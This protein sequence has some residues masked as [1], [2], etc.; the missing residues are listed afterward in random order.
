MGVFANAL[1]IAIGQNSPATRAIPREQGS[2]AAFLL[3]RFHR[4][5]Q[6]EPRLSLVERINLA[7]RQTVALI[8][9]DGQKFLVASSP[10][11][12][13]TFYALKT[14]GRSTVNR[15]RKTASEGK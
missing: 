6:K 9:A 5:A 4:R 8:E 2:L 7:P 10:D 14:A 3:D 11:G 1:G 13:P 15:T 12:A